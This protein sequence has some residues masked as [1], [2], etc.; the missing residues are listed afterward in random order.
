MTNVEQTS[1]K[2]IRRNARG[3][4]P[5]LQLNLAQLLNAARL[6][7][8][9]GQVEFGSGQLWFQPPAAAWSRMQELHRRS[10]R[11]AAPVTRA[12]VSGLNPGQ[13]G[14]AYKNVLAC[15]LGQL[16][17][18]ADADRRQMLEH[19]LDY[20]ER[21]RSFDGLESPFLSAMIVAAGASPKLYAQGQSLWQQLGPPAR[22]GGGRARAPVFNAETHGFVFLD[23]SLLAGLGRGQVNAAALAAPAQLGQ[24]LAGMTVKAYGINAAVTATDSDFCESAFRVGGAIVGGVLGYLG[25]GAK[26]GV[27][28]ASLG[29]D[30]GEVVGSLVCDWGK[31]DKS[32]DG[33]GADQQAPGGQGGAPSGQE[34][35]PAGPAGQGG[36]GPGGQGDAGSGQGSGNNQG[37][38]G[39]SSNNDTDNQPDDDSTDPLTCGYPPDDGPGPFQPFQIESST[40]ASGAGLRSYL[41]PAGG[42]LIVSAV[43]QLSGSAVSSLGFLQGVPGLASKLHEVAAVGSLGVVSPTVA[44]ANVGTLVGKTAGKVGTL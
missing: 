26:G 37:S 17:V 35:A 4:Y 39:S 14:L 34:G 6:V 13:A 40:F 15:T 42:A 32:N 25:G 10:V 22:V 9:A 7:S 2:P 18:I 20:V 19:L 43:P 8:A 41:H 21:S 1:F 27:E 3:A 38:S 11:S 30:A 44:K 29:K 28:G 36:A 31:T 33:P 12:D 16:M 5:H 23:G 24:V